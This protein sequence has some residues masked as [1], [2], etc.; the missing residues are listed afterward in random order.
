MNREADINRVK[1]AIEH[2]KAAVTNIKNI[3]AENITRQE[4]NSLNI[5]VADLGYLVKRLTHLMDKE[6]PKVEQMPFDCLP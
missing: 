1:R 3:D 2:I 4:K 5:T 6:K